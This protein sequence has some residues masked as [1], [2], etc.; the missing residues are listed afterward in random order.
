MPDRPTLPDFPIRECLDGLNQALTSGH[1]ILTAATGSGKTTIVPISLLQQSWLDGKKIIMLE[2]RRP[3]ARMAARRMASLLNEKVGE[4]VGYQVRFDRQISRQTRI[5]VLTEGLLLKRLQHDPELTGTG[6]IIFDEFHERSLVADLSMALCID[7]CNNL[8]EDL[9]LLVMSASIQT[10]QLA[11]ILDA[12][13][14]QATG[15]LYPVEV[16]YAEQDMALQDSVDACVTLVNLALQKVDR[17]ILVFLPGRPEIN[18]LQ[19]IAEQRWSDVC[20]VMPLHGELNNQQQD[21][22]LNYAAHE[23]RRLILATDIAETSLTIEGIEAV[24]DSGRTKKPVFKADSGLTALQTRWISKASAL[25]RQGRAGR[26]GPGVCFRAWTQSRQQRMDDF[27]RPEILDADLATLVLE[28]AMW[29]VTN[30]DDMQWLDSPPKGHWQQAG[31]LLYQLQAIDKHGVITAQGRNMAALPLHPRLSHMLLSAGGG[32]HGQQTALDLAAILSDRDPFLRQSHSAMPVDI[33]QRLDELA[34]W[35]K[36]GNSRYA[37]SRRL[38]QIDRL[39]QQFARLL[40]QR[41]DVQISSAAAGTYLALSY[42][43]RIAAQRGRAHSFVMRNGRGVTLPEEDS[44]AGNGFLVIA[45][46]DA[47]KRDG[48][49]FLAAAISR[50]EIESLF[51]SQIENRRQVFWDN[52][53]QSVV[54]RDITKLGSLV[55]DEKEDSLNSDDEVSELLLEYIRGNGLASLTDKR[56]ASLQARLVMIAAVQTGKDWPDASENGLLNSLEQWLLPWLEG[57]TSRRQLEKTD[58]TAA[59]SAWAGYERLQQLNSLLPEIFETAAQTQR[60][61]VYTINNPPALHVPLQEML[62]ISETPKL[63]QGS[64]ELVLYLLSPAGR[65]LQITTDLAG[66]WQDAYTEVKKQMRGRYP[67]HYWPDDPASAQATRFTK[68]RMKT[69]K[70]E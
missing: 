40:P 3:A 54:A 56:F 43:D 48:R 64:I 36:T 55:L 25:Q 61:I 41:P 15:S 59:L 18:R 66:F 47:G 68:N 11:G 51:A 57:V 31:E 26:L 14:V 13:H 53:R 46:L 39:S 22:V 33:T 52:S 32:D 23:K 45:S 35:R 30:A 12:Q 5:E 8:R 38:R 6:L 60:K 28:L 44:L 20:E 17:D 1:V 16:H 42:P 29:G 69:G 21:R 70:T 67:K 50:A 62:G 24:V 37:D 10:S 2:P 27:I 9:R 65:P 7:V 19:A 63:A 58:F 34:Q 4:T 49:A